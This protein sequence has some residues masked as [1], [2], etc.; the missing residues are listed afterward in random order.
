MLVSV[1]EVSEKRDPEQCII[2]F[3]ADDVSRENAETGRQ[4]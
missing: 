3:I 2:K 4:K 1:N